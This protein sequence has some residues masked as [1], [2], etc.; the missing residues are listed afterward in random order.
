MTNTAS[1][2]PEPRRAARMAPLATLPVF[3][4]L[5]G[6]RV[7]VVGGDPAA[8]W[9]AE[10]LSAAGA[11]VDV[12]E[13]A[14]CDDMMALA[15]DPPGG[16]ITLTG[17]SWAMADLAD[18]AFAVGS[19][20]DDEEAARFRDA[21]RIAGVP[22]NV[23]DRPAFC[24]VQFGGIVNRSPLV[25]GISTD[26]AAPVF[27]QAIRARIEALL[28][29]GLSRWAAAAKRWRKRA[30]ALGLPFRA[31][32]RF[33]EMFSARAL[34][35]PSAIPDDP[36][37]VAMEQA[38]L[39]EA[40]TPAGRIVLVGAG[41][42]DPELLTM[43][44]VRALQ[45]AD[46]IVHDDLVPAAILDVARRESLR[47][48]AGKRGRGP[49]CR[50]EDI[51]AMI[52]RLAREGRHVVRLK[53]GCPLVFGRAGE[54]IAAAR[55]AGIPVDVVPGISAAQGA[56]ATLTASLTHRDHARRIQFVTAHGRDGR[57]PQ[58]LDWAALADP[59]ASTAVYMAGATWHELADRLV[60]G[61]L[62][63]AT[64]AVAVA[65]ATRPDETVIA[66]TVATL[67][68]ALASRDWSGPMVI[69]VGTAFADAARHNALA[70]PASASVPG[71]AFS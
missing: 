21:A 50:Q 33:W 45:S 24:D 29:Q 36:L 56:A 27:G 48:A 60:A 14:P 54:E 7:V 30:E 43:K 32:R 52:V 69:L 37:A 34:A 5:A 59:A 26:G 3:L 22:V 31:R 28:P 12:F 13:A 49:S 1:R 63:P 38:A 68:A 19:I 70:E 4:K 55:A 18:A 61:G 46:V 44:A 8:V 57:L 62:D 39:A 53:A 25:I 41:P 64:P 40:A 66:A 71:P 51:N 10:L 16:A 2:Q 58:D 11:R 6:R 67:A 35:E 23:I 15:A 65:S 42:G 17:G 20:A 47:I 9:K